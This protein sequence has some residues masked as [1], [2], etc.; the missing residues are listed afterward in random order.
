MITDFK[1][2]K[3]RGQAS[4]LVARLFSPGSVWSDQ[5]M[6][7][8][9]KNKRFALGTTKTKLTNYL[10]VSTYLPIETPFLERRLNK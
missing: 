1:S 8:A 10:Y 5:I 2:G 9:I 4:F 3:R 7:S 6:N